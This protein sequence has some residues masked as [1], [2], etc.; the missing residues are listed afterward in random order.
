M[1]APWTKLSSYPIYTPLPEERASQ[2]VSDSQCLA[3]CRISSFPGGIMWSGRWPAQLCNHRQAPAV[4][5][6]RCF[7]PVRKCAPSREHATLICRHSSAHNPPLSFLLLV[8]CRSNSIAR[9][10]ATSPR[11]ARRAHCHCAPPSAH[12]A[13]PHACYNKLLC[14]CASALAKR[15]PLI[16]TTRHLA[17]RTHHLACDAT[18]AI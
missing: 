13:P 17:S 7:V 8:S 11:A 18:R 15:A 3:S 14:A 12:A 16:H 5:T 6:H 10:P 9:C 1:R 4:K 2:E